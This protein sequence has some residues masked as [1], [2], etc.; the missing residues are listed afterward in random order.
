[1]PLWTQ[2]PL[3]VC[4]QLS[5]VGPSHSQEATL[6]PPMYEETV[7]SS[8]NHLPSPQITVLSSTLPSPRPLSP[9][10]AREGAS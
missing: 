6:S 10:V 5:E 1:M 2:T 3:S 7:L 9:A 8:L 4:T